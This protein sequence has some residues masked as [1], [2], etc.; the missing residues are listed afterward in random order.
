MSG[1]NHRNVRRGSEHEFWCPF[2]QRFFPER[3]AIERCRP[4]N[5]EA[6]YGKT[7]V[8]AEAGPLL[9]QGEKG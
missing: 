8:K 6:Y 3:K 5:C 7:R 2:H 1:K 4:K 9:P